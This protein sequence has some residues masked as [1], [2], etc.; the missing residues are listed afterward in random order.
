MM[1]LWF[2]WCNNDIKQFLIKCCEAQWAV[3][4]VHKALLYVHVHILDGTDEW[5]EQKT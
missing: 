3:S 1:T 2:T 4:F 5:I